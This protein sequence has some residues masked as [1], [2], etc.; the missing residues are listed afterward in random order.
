MNSAWALVTGPQTEPISREAAK[1]NLRVVVSD[2]DDLVDRLVKGARAQVELY[3]NRGLLP[4]TWKYT[5][6]TWSDVI[7]LPRAPL[8]SVTSVKY[9]DGAGVLQTLATSIY[10]V[11]ITAEPGLVRRA[12][13]QVWPT[14]QV[15]RFAA[16]EV[17]YLVGYSDAASVPPGIVDG[18]H[19]LLSRR[20]QRR[21]D[22]A[23]DSNGGALDCPAAE[24]LLAPYRVFWYPPKACA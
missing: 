20:Y 10:Q 21:G 4:Q 18:I 23:A 15:G 16:V 11:D 6:D 2:E 3:L 12:P 22:E 13:N 1:L 14:L 8:R 7:A 5:Q 19:L 9:Y 24:A 17:T